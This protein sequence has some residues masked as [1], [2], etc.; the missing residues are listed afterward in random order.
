MGMYGHDLAA[1]L[2]Q[3]LRADPPPDVLGWLSRA[4]GADRVVEV[5]ALPGGMSSAVHRVALESSAGNRLDVVLRRYVL[6]W[7]AEE[8]DVPVNEVEVLTLLGDASVPAPRLLAA[9]P[10]GSAT[11][12]P[13]V[14]MSYLPGDVVWRPDDR[15]A[16]LRGLVDAMLLVHAQSI[17]GPREWSP[18][19]PSPGLV[20]PPWT[21]DVPAW[22]RALEA[23]AGS[24]PSGERVF[25]HR[26]YHP[27]NLLW[28]D[29]RV[30]GIVDWA[31]ACAG[32]AEVDVAHCRFNLAVHAGDADAAQHF[33][34]LW[35]SI[36]GRD[37]YDPYW[38]LVTAVSVV[39]DEPDPALDAFVAAAASR[40]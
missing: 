34:A 31:S 40:R 16:W 38:D 13:T 22:E 21:R 8:P 35:Q 33:L 24:A 27:G 29:R 36:T 10:D 6:D 19:A 7:V 26:D 11:G 18:Y 1:S 2:E 37:S 39:D 23:Y 25:L 9:D 4:T 28:T 15:A 14:V 5:R 17:G 30:S 3:A 32:P 20:P 12:T